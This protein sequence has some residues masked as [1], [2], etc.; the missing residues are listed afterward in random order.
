MSAV[1]PDSATQVVHPISN[2]RLIAKLRLLYDKY[3]SETCIEE[4]SRLE[5]LIEVTHKD[6][7]DFEQLRVVKSNKVHNSNKGSRSRKWVWHSTDDSIEKELISVLSVIETFLVLGIHGWLA[8]HFE[9]QWWLLITSVAAPIILL[10]SSKSINLGLN[11]LY[12]YSKGLGNAWD[13]LILRQKILYGIIKFLASFMVVSGVAY[14]LLPYY[15]DW[16]LFWVA[17]FLSMFAFAFT[18]AFAFIGTGMGV[19]AGRVV[20]GVVA[21]TIMLA[22][23]VSSVRLDVLVLVG[24]VL[25][26]FAGAVAVA[27][28]VMGEVNLLKIIFLMVIFPFLALGVWLRSLLIRIF[29]T[30]LYPIY[31]LRQLTSNWKENLWIVDCTHLPELLPGARRVDDFFSIKGLLSDLS[32]QQLDDKLIA[33]MA[34]TIWYPPAL[35]WRWSLKATLWLWWPLALLLKPPFKNKVLAE[36]DEIADIVSLRIARN[37]WLA[38]VA[39]LVSSWL[40][41]SYFPQFKDW[42]DTLGDTISKPLTKLLEIT[43]PSFGLRQLALWLCCIAAGALWVYATKVQLWHTQ[44]LA[45]AD[46][47]QDFPKARLEKFIQRAKVLERIYTFVVVSFIILGYSIILYLAQTYYPEYAKHFIPVWL[48]PYL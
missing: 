31:G 24:V 3:N 44:I 16:G 43:P 14:Y 20:M 30:L 8:F 2:T 40:I 32:H 39:L 23:A 47:L 9:R 4:R 17:F 28:A 7:D 13:V 34:T 33:I 19:G 48:V 25:G 29:A 36:I 41:L 5:Y 22:L 12:S 11:W 46:N 35:L 15:S 6:L 38:F 18:L 27:V 21:S 26:T 42:V 10:K 37:K 45:E 1:P